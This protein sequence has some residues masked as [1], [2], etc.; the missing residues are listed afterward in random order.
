MDYEI[1]YN[2]GFE[3]GVMES[4]YS[5]A[6]QLLKNDWKIEDIARITELDQD[7]IKQLID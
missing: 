6:Y 4:K 2:M 1:S 5:A 3:M 7:Q